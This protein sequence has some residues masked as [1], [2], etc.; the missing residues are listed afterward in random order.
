MEERYATIVYDN[1]VDSAISLE[2]NGN[3]IFI[4]NFVYAGNINFF[5]QYLQA[6]ARVPI[7]MS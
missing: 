6:A 4:T 1:R 5:S 2:L 3:S 7:F